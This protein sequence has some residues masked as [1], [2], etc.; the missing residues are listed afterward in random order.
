MD[1][2]KN[3]NKPSKSVSHK[4]VIATLDDV[5]QVTQPAQP[6]AKVVVPADVDQL[7]LSTEDADKIRV[8]EQK[9]AAAKIQLADLEIQL[10]EQNNRKSEI[11]GLLKNTSKEMVDEVNKIATSYGIDVNSQNGR[12]WNLNTAEMIF[13][14]VK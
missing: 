14:E 2:K 4:P 8:V 7:P 5:R 6:T 10:S 9:V 11:L 12:K 3:K 1:K 13:R